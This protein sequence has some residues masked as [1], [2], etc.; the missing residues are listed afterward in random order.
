M[1]KVADVKSCQTGRLPLANQFFER[2]AR[3][4]TKQCLLI[5]NLYLVFGFF[6]LP[7][8]AEP[9][10]KLAG[11]IRN[12]VYAIVLLVATFVYARA[13]A[14]LNPLPARELPDH[15]VI[16]SIFILAVYLFLIDL[17]YYWYHRAQH[18]FALLWAI[19]ELHHS[20]TEVNVTTSMRSYWLD[21]PL[22]S[23]II[24][25]PVS[26]LVGIDARAVLMMPFVLT[27][28]LFFA[29]ANLRLRLG[30]LTPV[31][32]GPHLHRIHHSTRPEHQNKNLAQFFPVFDVLFGTY[33]APARDEFPGTG[34]S[35][36]ASD[37]RFLEVIFRPFRIWLDSLRA[38]LKSLS[39][40]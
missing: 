4:M 3:N 34:T 18:R 15:G 9:G 21:R 40:F 7:F 6:E 16:Y 31:I 36:L 12:I 33:Y 29:H 8:R 25:L 14:V 27:T 23:F 30:F 5:I 28:W 26:Y 10:H 13:I 1:A 39:R 32:C 37:A 24:G 17:M 2:Q 38:Y 22:Q 35:T 19:H 20:D 11:R